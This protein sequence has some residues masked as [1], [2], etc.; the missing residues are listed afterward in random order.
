MPRIVRGLADGYF[1]HILNRGN[2][3]QYVFHKDEDFQAFLD[4][5]VEALECYPVDLCPKILCF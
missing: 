4:L 2:G 1:Y 5:L 3:R